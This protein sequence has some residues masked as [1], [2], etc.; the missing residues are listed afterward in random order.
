MVEVLWKKRVVPGAKGCTCA[1]PSTHYELT[2]F[3]VLGPGEVTGHDSIKLG[4]TL[5][6]C[7][8]RDRTL[9]RAWW[10]I[11]HV[12]IDQHRIIPSPLRIGRELVE[13]EREV[14]DQLHAVFPEPGRPKRRAGSRKGTKSVQKLPD[15]LRVLGLSLPCCEADVRAAFKRLALV[16]HPDVGGDAKSFIELKRAFDEAMTL[17]TVAA[18]RKTTNQQKAA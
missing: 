8:L 9:A 2:A 17:V 18:T 12:Q 3:A 10:N 7:R 1:D 16:K 6:S 15:C 5:S 13:H 4:A 14:L 11:V